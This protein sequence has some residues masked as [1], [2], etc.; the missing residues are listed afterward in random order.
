[1]AGTKP[2]HDERWPGIGER[3]SDAV[4][5]TAMARPRPV[6]SALAHPAPRPFV[7]RR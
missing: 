6:E 7:R 2:G 4:L 1:M 3:G 5:L